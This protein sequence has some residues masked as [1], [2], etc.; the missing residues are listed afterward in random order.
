MSL[1]DTTNEIPYGYCQC[2][3]G[4][5]APLAPQTSKRFGWIA[6][7]PLR[8]ILGHRIIRPSVERFWEKVNKNAPNGC[9]EWEGTTQI[10]GYGR[11]WVDGKTALAHRYAWQLEHGPI[12]HGLEVCH[13]C[14]N[15]RCVRVS[16]LFLGTPA[17]N[18]SDMVKKSRQGPRYYRATNA[19]LTETQV[20]EIRRRHEREAITHKALAIEYGVNRS[21]ITR[22]IRRD[23]WQ[24]VP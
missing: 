18:S 10:G 23:T 5:H 17:E 16:H 12:P 3:C 7:K 19:K 1:N 9:W 21:V 13:H 14:D 22:I 8:F 24:H 11:F 6:G 20:S 4:Q 2:G 15:P